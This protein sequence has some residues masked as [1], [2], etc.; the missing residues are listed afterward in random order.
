MTKPGN[1]V[2]SRFRATSIAELDPV[3]TDRPSGR[4]IVVPVVIAR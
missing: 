4:E 2:G 3:T 1:S